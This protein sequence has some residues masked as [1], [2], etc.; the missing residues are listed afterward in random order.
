MTDQNK[1]WEDLIKPTIK[2]QDVK[3]LGMITFGSHFDDG[4]NHEELKR[5]FYDPQSYDII[6]FEDKHQS[7][8]IG[9]F[10][11]IYKPKENG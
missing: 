5:M 6:P 9:Y 4:L 3:K 10:T 1:T 2:T 8:L 11:P 7:G